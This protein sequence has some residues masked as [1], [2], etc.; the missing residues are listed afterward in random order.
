MSCQYSTTVLLVPACFVGT[1]FTGIGGFS[2]GEDDRP[3]GTSKFLAV[4]ILVGCILTFFVALVSM[5]TVRTYGK[6]FGVV[7]SKRGR[8]NVVVA[9]SSSN[10]V[11]R[12]ES[13]GTTVNVRTNTNV[14]STNVNNQHISQLEQQNRLLQQQL[15]LQQQLLNQQQQQGGQFAGGLYPPTMPPHYN[16]PDPAFPPTAPPPPYDKYS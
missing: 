16:D 7:I 14:F 3:Q 2:G 8:Q 9:N 4:V 13:S 10:A 5:S 1:I 15:T 6:Y 11:G 12:G